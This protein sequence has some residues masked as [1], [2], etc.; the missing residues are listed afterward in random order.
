MRI[1]T[2]LGMA[3]LL[4]AGCKSNNEL[5]PIE[6]GTNGPFA[7]NITVTDTL[8]HP[9]K[10]L[11]VSIL[12]ALAG[13]QSPSF[14]PSRPSGRPLAVT[15]VGADIAAASRVTI[16]VVD[17]DNRPVATIA[18]ET[19]QNPGSYL[20]AW[21]V[22]R[23]YPTRVF[24]CRLTARDTATG[25]VLF[26]DSNYAVLWQRDASLAV[27][28][29]TSASGTFETRDSLLFP[30]VLTLPPMIL[31]SSSGPTP[32]GEFTVRDTVMIVLTDSVSQQSQNYPTVIV[33]GP[34]AISLTWA[35]SLHSPTPPASEPSG[36]T[37]LRLA[38]PRNGITWKLWQNYPNPFD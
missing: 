6:G 4:L 37:M 31:T 13:V 10:G 21:S 5:I 34:N 27:I 15:N 3:A 28:G 22:P 38:G 12:S 18:D 26:V 9:V 2:F 32:I 11:Q 24:K 33:N 30:N 14:T 19:L 23:D 29:T 20:F 16:A 35:P 7:V 17:L 8:Q 1:S 36:G 25:S